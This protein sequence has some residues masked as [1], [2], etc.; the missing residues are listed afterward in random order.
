MAGKSICPVCKEPIPPNQMDVVICQK[1]GEV[2]WVGDDEP[3]KKQK[4][5]KKKKWSDQ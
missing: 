4:F 3:T 2:I 1:C 5:K